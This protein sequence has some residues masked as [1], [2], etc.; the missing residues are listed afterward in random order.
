VVNTLRW[1]TGRSPL[2]RDVLGS[3]V[4]FAYCLTESLAV[5]R[6]AVKIEV[7]GRE[8]LDRPIAEGG[9]ARRTGAIIATAHIG[10]W[11]VAAAALASELDI[12]LTL[13]MEAE[14][15]RDARILHDSVRKR[16]G[17]RIAHVGASWLDAL[18]LLRRLQ[19][20]EVLAL[21]LDRPAPSGRAVRGW[22]FGR[23]FGVPEGIFKLAQLSG[24]P[25]IPVFS[26][27]SGFFSHRVRVF[28]EIRLSR[29]APASELQA[30]AQVALDCLETFVAEAPRQWFFFHELPPET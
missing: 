9:D 10:A 17:L 19:K 23:Q 5:G 6:R 18:P 28:P 12:S 16:A 24:A 1:I 21:Q 15:D 22:L 2:A 20:G 13:V 4:D 8:F 29:R 26:R 11:D 30:A 3:F 14:A 27:R 25:I 7:A